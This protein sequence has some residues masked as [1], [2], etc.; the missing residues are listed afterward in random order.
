M[1]ADAVLEDIG[2][3]VVVLHQAGGQQ[4]VVFAELDGLVY[5]A[6]RQRHVG[7]HE[8]LA[9]AVVEAVHVVVA[10]VGVGDVAGQGDELV[11][12]N[13]GAHHVG[14]AVGAAQVGSRGH[15]QAG[16]GVLDQFAVQRGGG[17]AALAVAG[18][19]ELPVLAAVIGRKPF[20]GG[21]QQVTTGAG[22]AIR[23]YVG[24]NAG[25]VAQTQVVGG[26]GDVALR[27][28]PLG[29]QALQNALAAGNLLAVTHRSVVVHRHGVHVVG[30]GRYAEQ[31]AGD[32]GLAEHVRRVVQ[33]LDVLHVVGSDDGQGQVQDEGQGG[34]LFLG[35][36]EDLGA[37]AGADGQ[38]EE[39][40]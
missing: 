33:D 10:R 4:G 37:A 1:L 23:V 28:D 25:V 34:V 8:D 13:G 3:D 16:R 39:Q 36:D 11:F 30:V 29:Q 32:G 5:E 26:N 38:N 18:Q 35:R 19:E 6:V 17:V 27:G 15:L 20:L 24:V 9:E 2:Q 22:F 31:A 21:E 12:E 40:G 7:R 14:D